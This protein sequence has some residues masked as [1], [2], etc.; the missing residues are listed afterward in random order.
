MTVATTCITGK[1][2]LR[3]ENSGERACAQD[4]ELPVHYYAPMPDH[5]R[6]SGRN[7][8]ELVLN[9]AVLSTVKNGGPE[10]PLLRMFRWGVSLWAYAPRIYGRT[11]TVQRPLSSKS[12]FSLARS[13]IAVSGS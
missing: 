7:V 11:R 13:T 12:R 5:S 6:V 9:I 1:T 2:A 8:E 4:I 3:L 10:C